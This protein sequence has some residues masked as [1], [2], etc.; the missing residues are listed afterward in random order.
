MLEN[1]TI[2][3]YQP[4][5]EM[6]KSALH[7]A[8]E[9]NSLDIVKIIIETLFDGNEMIDTQGRNSIKR[10]SKMNFINL[11]NNDGLTAIHY[12]AFR[13]NIRVLEYLIK[14][15]GNPFIK[16]NDGHNVIHIAAQGDKVNVIHYF[17]KNF[18]FDVN[19]RDNKDSSALHW[20]AYLNKEISLTYLIAWGANVNAQDAEKNTPLHLAVLTSE[21]VM[22]TRWVKILLLKGSKRNLENNRGESARDLVKPGEM[23]D[24]LHSILKEQRYCTWLMLKVPLAKIDR[25]ERTAV[26]FFVLYLIM[27]AA[28]VLYIIPATGEY[29]IECVS[30]FSAW[31]GLLFLS[32]ILASV[33]NPG[34]IKRDPNIDF[35]EL[36]DNTDAYNVWPDCKIIRTP[37]SRH[38]NICNM[39]VERFDHHCPYINN[40]VGYRNHAFFLM[41]ISLLV[42][43]MAV[44]VALWLFGIIKGFED[45]DFWPF[46]N[47]FHPKI[48]Y[49]IIVAILF[50]TWVFFFPFTFI[51]AL[52]HSWNF[53]RNKTT[54]ERFA[55][56]NDGDNNS[57]LSKSILD[58]SQMDTTSALLAND[59]NTDTLLRT[60]FMGPKD[61]SCFGNCFRMWCYKPPSQKKMQME[62]L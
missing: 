55:R 9:K 62:Y 26:F 47:G 28:S 54:N 5:D 6:N 46:L 61:G 35:Q 48:F 37:R 49:Y 17:I 20:S 59:S 21:K 53:C 36:L 8:C 51:L 15:G 16:D 23:H 7:W 60:T 13:G 56:K 38:W 32:F 29:R 30:V 34:Y 2:K 39:C 40:C 3:F 4:I 43:N 11:Q 24:E 44:I 45:K 18:N 27:N 50:A 25:N 10:I 22:E 1:H 33:V 12:A 52:V 41:F 14:N 19:D 31:S 42:I 58:N 57:V